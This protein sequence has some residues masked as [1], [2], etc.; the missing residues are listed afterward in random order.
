MEDDSNARMELNALDSLFDLSK[1][2]RSDCVCC[3]RVNKSQLLCGWESVNKINQ[4][5]GA[6]LKVKKPT[7][8]NKTWALKCKNQGTRTNKAENPN[9]RTSYFRNYESR[10][11]HIEGY[12]NEFSTVRPKPIQDNCVVV[13][14]VD[15][16]LPTTGDHRFVTSIIHTQSFIR[17]PS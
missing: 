5:K 17:N 4:S 14:N 12:T 11:K 13:K 10:K 7:V 8:N 2:A 9:N 16:Y 3:N 15:P 6:R 1:T